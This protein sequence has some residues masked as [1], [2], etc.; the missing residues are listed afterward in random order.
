M[1]EAFLYSQALSAII[2]RGL[3]RSSMSIYLRDTATGISKDYT[4]W[5]V[6]TQMYQLELPRINVIM[7][8]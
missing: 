3:V 8:L 2:T 4:I 6:S 5:Y 1:I 7:A